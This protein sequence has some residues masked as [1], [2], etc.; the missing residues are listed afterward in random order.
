MT[1]APGIELESIE[2]STFRDSGLTSVVIPAS[3]LRIGNNGF[4]GIES[5]SSVTFANNSLLE[6]IGEYAFEYTIL[7]SVAI[8]KN[9]YSIASNAFNR[10]RLSSINVV[11][12][13]QFFTSEDGVLF[14]DEKVTLLKYPEFKANTYYSVP[15]SVQTIGRQAFKRSSF[16]TSVSIPASVSEIEY[17]AFEQATA[18]SNVSFAVNSGLTQIND[19]VFSELASLKTMTLPSSISRIHIFSFYGSA[20]E[21]MTFL[22]NQFQF[23][24]YS[25]E[26]LSRFEG[27]REDLELCIDPTKAWDEAITDRFGC[28]H[29]LSFVTNGGSPVSMELFKFL[30]AESDEPEIGDASSQVSRAQIPE[31]LE[32]IRAGYS[33]SGWSTTEGGS[34]EVF[35]LHLSGPPRDVVFYAK[36]TAIPGYADESV[37]VPQN[38]AQ[39]SPPQNI[40]QPSPPQ[41]LPT[42]LPVPMAN[43]TVL[44]ASGSKSLVSKYQMDLKALVE[45][46]GFGAKYTVNASASM[47][48]GVPRSY[49]SS[50]AKAR[51]SKIKSHLL[52]LGVRSSD[53][54]IKLTVNKAGQ[55]PVTKITVKK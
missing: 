38:N 39:P 23:L 35:P 21:R 3:V 31:P 40:P 13:N 42:I 11:E 37:N 18:L 4:A 26:D 20:L 44:F 7:T 53:I 1:F 2:S 36:W 49:I 47:V 9:V 27:V 15:A 52:K 17:S 22:G 12:P 28:G 55:R 24:T 45:K 19:W 16:L 6:T 25:D 48:R 51:A 33:F 46:T 34:S 30:A 43:F 54:S 5:L 10:T 32:P 41:V 50:L 14:D 8:P 29:K